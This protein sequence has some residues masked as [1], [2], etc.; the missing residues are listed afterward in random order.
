[1]NNSSNNSSPDDGEE[2]GELVWNEFDWERYLRQRD[3]AVTAYQRCYDQA[4]ES[5]DRLDDVARQL[6]WEPTLDGDLDSDEDDDDFDDDLDPYTL[7]RNPVYVATRALFASLL[8]RLESAAIDGRSIAPA[9]AFPLLRTLNQAEMS[10]VLGVQSLDLGD[11]ALGI[12]QLKRALGLLNAAMALVPDSEEATGSDGAQ[13][14][15]R[16]YIL[17]RLFDLR[18]ICLRVVRECRQELERPLDDED[19]P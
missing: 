8:L 14:G 16:R 5:P 15:L 2:H 12:S 4:A 6:G 3:E 7:H 19:Q 11:S 1:M 10:V 18:E 9:Q 17:P 13:P